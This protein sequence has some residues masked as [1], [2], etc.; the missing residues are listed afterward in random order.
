MMDKSYIVCLFS[1]LLLTCLQLCCCKALSNVHDTFILVPDVPSQG[2]PKHSSSSTISQPTKVD[3]EGVIAESQ[4][5]PLEPL[6]KESWHD[7]QGQLRYGKEAA[8]HLRYGKEVGDHVRYGKEVAPH[9]RY[10]KEASPHLRYGKEVADHVRYGKE[11]APHLRYGKEVADHVRY[12]K[13]AA[14][15]LRYG[16]EVDDHVRYG[17]EAAPHLR[18]GKEIDDHVR[19]GRGLNDH[20]RYGREAAPHLRYGKELVQYVRYGRE[21]GND[22][23]NMLMALGNDVDKQTSDENKDKD[24]NGDGMLLKTLFLQNLIKTKEEQ[25]IFEILKFLK[26]FDRRTIALKVGFIF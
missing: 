22:V 2:P 16:K 12:G 11:A 26:D 5:G 1:M 3:L 19:Y 6:H 13:E 20:V 14:P 10:G 18:Y 15:H 9:L 17:K 7:Q 21:A 8:P 25:K 24:D 23:E 4:L